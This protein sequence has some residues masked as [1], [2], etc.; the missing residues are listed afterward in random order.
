MT[1]EQ[2]QEI[3]EGGLMLV[4]FSYLVG[5]GFGMIFKIIRLAISERF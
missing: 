5:F 1:P 4:V 2:M 3:F